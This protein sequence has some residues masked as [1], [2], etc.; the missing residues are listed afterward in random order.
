MRFKIQLVVCAEGGQPDTTH[1]VAVL[2]KECRR[3]EHLGLTLSE[4]KQLL[5]Q[6]QRHMVQQQATAYLAAHT[7]CPACGTPLHVKEQTTRTVRTLF[8]VIILASPR[9]YH[10]RC[11][12]RPATTFRPLTALLTESTTPELLFLEAKWA[13]LISY[14]LTARVLKDFLP[15][16]ERLNATTVQNHTLAVAQRCEEELSRD[17]DVCVD[18]RPGN[19]GP[20]SRP[21][22]PICVGLDGGY[23]RDWEQKHRRFEVIVG[24]AVPADQPPKCFGFVQ[25]YD[26]RAKQRLGAVLQSQGVHNSQPLTFLS[27]GAETVR[28]LPVSLHPHSEH[29]IDW[30]HISM[31]LTVLGQLIKGL[32]RLSQEGGVVIQQKLESVKWSLWHGKVDK[33]LERLGESERLM[34]P[35]VDIY[36]R[37]PQLAKAVQQ[38]RTYL[39]HNRSFLP[40][41]GK[42][43]RRGETISTA[44]VESTI[45]SVLSKRFVKRQSMQWTKR[46]AHLLLQTRTKTLNNELAATFRHWYPD[47]Q[48]EEI[49]L[50]A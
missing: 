21:E 22:G 25:S 28:N 39:E 5:N 23:V 17:Q 19:G 7:Q 16:D 6:L 43:Y 1:E 8:G 36:P 15:V 3:I 9:L 11:Q 26:T 2:E 24:K 47:F 40:N 13:S 29:L 12:A 4:A 45:N 31:R 14:G 35:F 10:C 37:F 30:F 42:R 20:S 41:Y 46:G 48:R 38:F 49:A 50:A 44:F 32:I 33:A 27:D 34:G 18:G